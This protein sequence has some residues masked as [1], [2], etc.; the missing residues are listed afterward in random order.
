LPYPSSTAVQSTRVHLLK[1][2]FQLDNK[3]LVIILNL[4]TI[5]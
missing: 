2:L 4:I 3:F 5:F 1:G